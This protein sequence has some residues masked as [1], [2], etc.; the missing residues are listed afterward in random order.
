M[1][2]P[3]Q[4]LRNAGGLAR[5]LTKHLFQVLAVLRPTL[6]PRSHGSPP[7]C[8]VFVKNERFRGVL[9]KGVAGLGLPVV[10][11]PPSGRD[12]WRSGG[13]ARCGTE[14]DWKHWAF[15]REA[16]PPSTRFW[17]RSRS[18]TASAAATGSGSRGSSFLVHPWSPSCWRS[19]LRPRSL[20]PEK[21]TAAQRLVRGG[22][23]FFSGQRSSIADLLPGR[24]S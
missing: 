11:R 12:P 23:S 9:G 2:A 21:G 17:W 24:T 3:V 19:C 1:V 7:L 20:L 14:R 8:T 10:P 18:Q 15:L 13:L 6:W 16:R 4:S 5:D 22:T